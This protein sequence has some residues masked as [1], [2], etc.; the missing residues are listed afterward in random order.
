MNVPI[1]GS[2]FPLEFDIN[3][4]SRDEVM[5]LGWIAI[6]NRLQW[7]KELDDSAFASYEDFEE[8]PGISLT[9]AG[10]KN[11]NQIIA[12]VFSFSVVCFAR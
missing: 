12:G 3:A 11:K 10:L 5:T 6:K 2:S 7:L 9:E 1:F 4:A 8:R